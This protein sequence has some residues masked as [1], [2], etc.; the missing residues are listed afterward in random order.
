MDF[1]KWLDM[2]IDE[3][4]KNPLFKEE[5]VGIWIN[6][7]DK[8]FTFKDII[9]AEWAATH[10]LSMNDMLRSGWVRM[11]IMPDKTAFAETTRHSALWAIAALADEHAVHRV[12]L[13][14]RGRESVLSKTDSQ[15]E[16]DGKSL[17][18]VFESKEK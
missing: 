2:R 8:V 11:R 4:T 6:P 12:Q 16:L 9:H 13:F 17:S 5:G 3:A 15:W 1:N 7:D 18:D 10:G 14:L